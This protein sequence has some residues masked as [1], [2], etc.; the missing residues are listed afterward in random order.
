MK[1]IIYLSIIFFSILIL[2]FFLFIPERP[3]STIQSGLFIL[4]SVFLAI[5][6]IYGIIAERL[7]KIFREKGSENICVDIFYY[8]KNK[9]AFVRLLLF[10]FMKIKSKNSLV[11]SFLG[12]LVWVIIILIVGGT[13]LKK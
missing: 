1:K 2:V 3:P 9:N 6:G 8:I 7:I 4:L 13:I 11:Y 5:F 10:P 12:A